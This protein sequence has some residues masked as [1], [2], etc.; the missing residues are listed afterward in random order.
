MCS[1]EVFLLLIC[2][3]AAS[4]CLL[5]HAFFSRVRRKFYVLFDVEI[6]VMKLS[7]LCDRMLGVLFEHGLREHW[8]G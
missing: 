2:I 8:R 5:C 1:R 4:S 7:V 3:V 6:V